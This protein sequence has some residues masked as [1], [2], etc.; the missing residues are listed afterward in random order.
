[1][2][3]TF[4]TCKVERPTLSLGSS[5]IVNKM[6]LF[7]AQPRAGDQRIFTEFKCGRKVVL[8]AEA[9]SPDSDL[10]RPSFF[11]SCLNPLLPLKPFR[12]LSFGSPGLGRGQGIPG[13]SSVT[14]T[15]SMLHF[16]GCQCLLDM[17]LI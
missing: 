9:L 7:R 17:S 8:G 14:V 12:A 13:T 11:Q 1:M 10:P 16:A 5:V 4:L 15:P 3:L 6:Q 2:C